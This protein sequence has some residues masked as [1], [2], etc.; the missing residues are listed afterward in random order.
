[1]NDRVDFSSGVGGGKK[2]GDT[3]LEP[4]TDT[5]HSLS[6]EFEM[7]RAEAQGWYPHKRGT[8][9]CIVIRFASSSIAQLRLQQAILASTYHGHLATC[10]SFFDFKQRLREPDMGSA[11][12]CTVSNHFRSIE[13][14]VTLRTRWTRRSTLIEIR[15]DLKELN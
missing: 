5:L 7:H 11:T 6:L 8:Q 13:S 9:T 1:M 4:H 14:R 15:L 2:N 10:A 12:A 3:R